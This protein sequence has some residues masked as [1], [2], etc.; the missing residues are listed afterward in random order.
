MT[1]YIWYEPVVLYD[2]CFG[3]TVREYF[4]KRI[5]DLAIYIIVLVSIFMFGN[6]IS[7][8]TWHYWI[9]KSLILFI[10]SNAFC[11]IIYKNTE[12]FTVISKKI[13]EYVIKNR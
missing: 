2:T 4:F 9:L 12:E 8:E 5:K 6:H 10:L 11:Y 1:T 13:E 7:G 3:V